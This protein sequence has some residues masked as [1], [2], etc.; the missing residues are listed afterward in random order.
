VVT[1]L[2]CWQGKLFV[3]HG[4]RTIKVRHLSYIY[5]NLSNIASLIRRLRSHLLAT[6]QPIF[7]DSIC[8]HPFC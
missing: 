1:A 7:K 2:L 3:G 6:E 8:L 4:D 5:C